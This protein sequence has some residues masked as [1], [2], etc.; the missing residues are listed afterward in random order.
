MM[1]TMMSR[2]EKGNRDEGGG[3]SIR[4]Q[5][6]LYAA[7]WRD[8]DIY[9]RQVC[10]VWSAHVCF[11]G[12]GGM[13]DEGERR[14]R[15]NEE[16]RAAKTVTCSFFP[17]SLARNSAHGQSKMARRIED[18]FPGRNFDRNDLKSGPSA[19]GYALPLIYRCRKEIGSIRFRFV[20]DFFFFYSFFSPFQS[21]N[22]HWRWFVPE[23]ERESK[24]F[25][26][27][28]RERTLKFM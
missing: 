14:K 25:A 21:R 5:I 23:R 1:T 20:S 6:E 12:E 10:D 17:S 3:N 7:C 19:L 8:N 16:R 15:E 22:W 26:P 24:G 11:A 18:F 9:A 27:G 2:V 13:G 28:I 4:L